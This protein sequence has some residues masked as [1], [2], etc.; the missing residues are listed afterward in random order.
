[1][2]KELEIYNECRRNI[3][4]ELKQIP[5]KK[6]CRSA[7]FTMEI[8]RISKICK[9]NR[10][11]SGITRNQIA[12]DLGCSITLIQRFEMGV[13]DN[14]IILIY[15]IKKGFYNVEKEN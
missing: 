2:D 6:G 12:K 3:I 1:M 5:N 14:C 8:E 10:I 9:E 13:T 11:K 4:N 15:Y 7:Y